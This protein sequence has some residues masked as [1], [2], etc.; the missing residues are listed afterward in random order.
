MTSNRSQ[1]IQQGA[2]TSSLGRLNF[3]ALTGQDSPEHQ[4]VLTS[5][6]AKIDEEKLEVIRV[7]FVD[8][9]GIVRMR[10]IEA[11]L[12]SQAVRNGVPFT[13]AL[14]RHGFRQHHFPKR[15]CPRWWLWPRYHGRRGGHAGDTR[16]QHIS[17]PALGAQ[18]RLGRE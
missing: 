13:T 1:A 11:R 15:L 9:H 6:L 2:A 8:T 16:P 18:M 12:F 17:R 3:A 14:L 7:A 5:I 4:E 10:P